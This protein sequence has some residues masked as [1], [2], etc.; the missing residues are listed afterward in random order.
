MTGSSTRDPARTEPPGPEKSKSG[1]HPPTIIVVGTARLPAS[2][3]GGGHSDSLAVEVEIDPYDETIIDTCCNCIPRLGEK[4]LASIL[5]G[6]KLPAAIEEAIAAIRN[7]Y[8]GGFQRALIAALEDLLRRHTQRVA[9]R[10]GR[11]DQEE[12]DSP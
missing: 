12:E 5:I 11:A 6:Q 10:E 1:T 3:V 4:L 9:A 8:F 2:A 7:R